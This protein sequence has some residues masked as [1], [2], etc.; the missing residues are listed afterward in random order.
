MW[1]RERDVC[2]REVYMCVYMRE[3]ERCVRG[4]GERGGENETDNQTDKEA[5]CD[6]IL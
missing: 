3:R 5:A 6:V 1:E 2:E 4:G